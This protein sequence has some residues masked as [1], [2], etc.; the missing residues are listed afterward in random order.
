MDVSE[1]WLAYNNTTPCLTNSKTM[2]EEQVKGQG[3]YLTVPACSKLKSGQESAYDVLKSTVSQ[4]K[5]V[6]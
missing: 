6:A 4:D 2:L 5:I 3:L 1:W